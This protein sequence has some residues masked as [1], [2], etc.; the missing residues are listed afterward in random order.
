MKKK[1]LRSRLKLLKMSFILLL[2]LIFIFQIATLKQTLKINNHYEVMTI[3]V[4][5]KERQ[6]Q[7]NQTLSHNSIKEITTNE[8]KQPIIFNIQIV[9]V[10]NADKDF[11]EALEKQIQ[12]VPNEIIESFINDNYQICITNEDIKNLLVNPSPNKL[13]DKIFVL[14]FLKRSDNIL[15]IRNHELV[16]EIYTVVH[17]FGHYADKYYGWISNTKEWKRIFKEEKEIIKSEVKIFDERELFAQIFSDIMTGREDNKDTQAYQYIK[18]LI[19]T[20][21]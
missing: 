19:E 1:R 5:G 4:N 21:S 2:F 9:N 6:V 16:I 13:Q 20:N 10:A 8:E 15:Y 14:G 12:L 18:E 7:D 17:E 3:T 11:M